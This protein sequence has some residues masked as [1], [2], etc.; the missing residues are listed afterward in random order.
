MP[1]FLTP[2]APP[3]ARRGLRLAAC[4]ALAAALGAC[5][6]PIPLTPDDLR[7]L[8][9]TRGAP[10]E[11]AIAAMARV[12]FLCDVSGARREQVDCTRMTVRLSS[13]IERIRFTVTSR[14]EIETIHTPAPV[15]TGAL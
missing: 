7:T 11:P 1:S 12:G 3:I 13:C 5:A 9:V 15:C 14:Q 6:S 10:S 8:G 4:G 2:F